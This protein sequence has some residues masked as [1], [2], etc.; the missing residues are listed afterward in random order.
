MKL[1][2]KVALVTGGGSGIGRATAALYAR[3]G[4]KVVITGRTAAR[5]ES[6]V[7][8][9]TA[10]GGT[11]VGVPGD[12]ADP[13]DAARAVGTCVDRFG[14]LDIAFLNAGTYLRANA[15]DTELADWDAVFRNNSRAA[16]VMT[17]AALPALREGGGVLLY[18]S[19]TIGL[20]PIPGVAAYCAAKAAVA[21]LSRS[22]ALEYGHDG[23]RS[24]CIAPGIVDTPI[25]DPYL[26]PKQ[27]D[28]QLAD[29]TSAQP[30]P[31]VGTP[32]DIARL[33]LFL[34][35]DDASWMTGEV[36]SID[37]GISLL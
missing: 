26:D 30:L 36:V 31:R 20:R 15:G 22:V 35:S 6:V 28:A 18:T 27:R 23:V 29:V 13:D 32:E 11:I 8:E 7:T 24:L 17:A 4:A 9:V 21:S 1:A 10:N 34:A 37:G 33:A 5:L 2:G 19:S 3:E 25:L 14:T 12:A 16:F